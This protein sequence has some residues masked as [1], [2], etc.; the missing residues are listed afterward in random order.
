MDVAKAVGV[1]VGRRRKVR[2]GRG[3]G[4]GLGKTSGRGSK[5]AASRSGF[6]GLIHREGGQMPLIRR[7][8]KRGFNNKLFR[9]EYDVINVDRLAEFAG[10]VVTP[11][12]LK[13]RGMLAKA[14]ARLKVLGGGELSAK[15]DVHA[16][17]FS[18][19]ARAKIE[20]SGGTC[21]LL[22]GK[23]APVVRKRPKAAPEGRKA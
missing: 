22:G 11:D 3:S 14:A 23:P 18:S 20:A 19:S 4:S 8:P 17:A 1:D 2:V 16:H 15:V 7:L 9:T 21:T 10:S 12:L 13:E 5:G 6:G